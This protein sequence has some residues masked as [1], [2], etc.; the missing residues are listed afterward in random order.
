MKKRIIKTVI[1]IFFI[2]FI[3]GGILQFITIKGENFSFLST[4]I[5]RIIIKGFFVG[6]ISQI[7]YLGIFF[8]NT[9]IIKGEKLDKM[10]KFIIVTNTICFLIYYWLVTTV[11]IS[12]ITFLYWP[13]LVVSF[14][15]DIGV[16]CKATYDGKKWNNR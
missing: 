6:L 10:Q 12:E 16:V 9:I 11:I 2:G 3:M 4:T 7:V 1:L 13:I 15:F 14:L 5:T 8:T